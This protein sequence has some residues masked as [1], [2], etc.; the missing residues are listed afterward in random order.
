M[1]EQEEENKR[2]IA[3]DFVFSFFPSLLNILDLCHNLGYG[4]GDLHPGNI[5]AT[6][7]N[8]H[9]K[10]EFMATL[11]DFDNSSIKE[12]VYCSTE[13]EK[14]ESDCR[15]FKSGISVGRNIVMDWEWANQVD[16]IFDAY[17]SIRELKIAFNSILK[18]V[19]LLNKG[20]VN[21]KETLAILTE[22]LH[23][24]MN[25]F[26]PKATFECLKE[27]SRIAGLTTEFERNYK[28]YLEMSKNY[29]TWSF[30]VTIIKNG[31]EKNMLYKKFFG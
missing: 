5:M 14:I 25:S 31:P 21:T 22:L 3:D 28:A 27:I 8:V 12:E 24:A 11:I 30:D 13:T 16:S 10:F 19:D 2:L 26:S 6:P 17:N 1:N 29:E 23:N 4:H 15:S 20:V 18:Y 7:T 9:E